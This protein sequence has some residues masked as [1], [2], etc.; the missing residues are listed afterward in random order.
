MRTTN[1]VIMIILIIISII[2]IWDLAGLAGGAHYGIGPAF[3]PRVLAVLLII[4][5]ISD[6]VI[7]EKSSEDEEVFRL[8]RIPKLIKV[9]I[10]LLLYISFMAKAGFIIPS[11]V[12]FISILFFIEKR[13]LKFSL[14]TSVTCVSIIYLLFDFILN[15][16]LPNDVLINFF[17]NL[18]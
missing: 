15:V 9:F 7:N 11:L 13:S 4:L 2:I 17:S 12:F 6:I 14:I 5:S 1:K 8:E 3:V 18:I 16:P 10:L